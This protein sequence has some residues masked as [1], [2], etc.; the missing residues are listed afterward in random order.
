L[1]VALTL[2]YYGGNRQFARAEFD[3]LCLRIN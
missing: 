3:C 1:V 2:F